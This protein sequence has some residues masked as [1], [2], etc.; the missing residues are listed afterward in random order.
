MKKNISEIEELI[1]TKLHD[2]VYSDEIRHYCNEREIQVISV[3]GHKLKA[4][5]KELNKKSDLTFEQ[6]ENYYHT[7]M[8]SFFGEKVIEKA[9]V[10]Y[11]KSWGYEKEQ[12]ENFIDATRNSIENGKKVVAEYKKMMEEVK[13][14][15]KVSTGR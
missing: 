6:L 2:F 15:K 7:L 14:G 13:K 8:D 11:E 4:E 5:L 10:A 12:I 1:E 3:M 9:E